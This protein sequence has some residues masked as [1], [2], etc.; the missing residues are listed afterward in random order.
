MATLHIYE[1][2]KWQ[3]QMIVS[4]INLIQLNMLSVFFKPKSLKG[5]S[6]KRYKSMLWWDAR[7][8]PAKLTLTIAW[9]MQCLFC[10]VWSV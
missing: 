8:T 6:D 5:E 10:S 4:E 9:T 3:M 7:K 1:I 2:Q